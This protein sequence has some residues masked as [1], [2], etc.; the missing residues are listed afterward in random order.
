M[1]STTPATRMPVLAATSAARIGHLLRGRLRRRHDQQ[2]GLRQ[3]LP[4]RDRDVAGAG[5]HVH[6][7]VVERAPVHVGQKLF[8]RAVQHR[9]APGDGAV[10][11]HEEA[12]RH[13]L[14]AVRDRRD[15]QLVHCHR[16]LRDAQHARHRVAVDVGVDH[17][18][19]GAAQRQRGGQVRGQRRL[20]DAALAGGDRDHPRARVEPS[21]RLPRPRRRR[22]PA[23]GEAPFAPPAT[24]RRRRPRPTRRRRR[25]PRGRAPGSRGSPSSGSPATVSAIVTAT[26][27][28]SISTPRTMS[29]STTLRRISGSITPTS[30]SRI[31]ACSAI[32]PAW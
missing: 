29:S 10:A 16:P 14:H 23:A 28:P 24:S 3:Q 30:A 2:V 27:P 32:N 12:D 1:F 9:A 6:H 11:L 15:H 4:Q 19:L 20:A 26:R 22:R 5:G 13:H 17:A 8:Q 21:R 18:H 7:Q 25:R 31:A